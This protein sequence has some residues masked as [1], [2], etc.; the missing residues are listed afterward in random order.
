MRA[1]N[2]PRSARRYDI[3]WLRIFVILLLFP[4]HSARIFDFWEPNYVKNID[5]SWGLSWFIVIVGYWFMPLMF[6]LAGASSWYALDSRDGLQYV[7]E[8]MSRLLIPF[9]FGILIIVPPQGYLAKLSNPGYNQTYFQFLNSYFRDFSDL[10]GYF[11]TF[12]P[13]HLWFILYLFIFSLLGLPLLLAL[14]TEC[15]KRGLAR[16][17]STFSK[18]WAYILGFVFLTATEALP[19]PGGK[20]P[21]FFFFLFL[22]GYITCADERFNTMIHRLKSKVLLFLIP[23]LP[24]YLLLLSKLSGFPDWSPESVMLAFIRNLALW[25]T[26]IVI[27]GYGQK[28]LNS[29]SKWLA[30]MNQAAFPIYVIHQTV[31]LIIGFLVVRI[32]LGLV[33]KFFSITVLSFFSCLIIYDLVIRRFGVTRWIFGVKAGSAPKAKEK[34]SM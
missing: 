14:K 22:T 25:L 23:Y 31:L 17:W 8:R 34:L 6:W 29:S 21:F 10:S 19:A 28:Y 20:N 4:F 33:P 18:P 30:Y 9:L 3:D 26:L 11:G 27:L 15:G 5:L 1:K 7:K 32:G 16:F 24:L 2:H 13:A 12:T